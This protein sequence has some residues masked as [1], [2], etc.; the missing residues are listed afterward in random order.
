M[1]DVRVFLGIANYYQRM[2]AGFASIAAPITG[3]LK[4]STVFTWGQQH[5]SVFESLKAALCPPPILAHADPRK[6]FCIDTD[7]SD[8]AIGAVLH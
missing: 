6:P 8:V 1:H 7:A 2:V 4:K 5:K 3:L